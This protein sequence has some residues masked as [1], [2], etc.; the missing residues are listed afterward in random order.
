MATAER[1]SPAAVVPVRPARRPGGS[2]GSGRG[3]AFSANPLPEH[4]ALLHLSAAT[5][6]HVESSLP[7][8]T[9]F[10]LHTFLPVVLLHLRG[11]FILLLLEW[12]E[13]LLI[14]RLK[15]L[16]ALDVF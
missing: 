5:R 15:C 7:P 16:Q 4:R 10:T 3:Q 6:G 11:R 1:T 9:L 12:I 14:H 2:G 8:G 13:F